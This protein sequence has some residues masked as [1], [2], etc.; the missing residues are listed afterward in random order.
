MG[1]ADLEAQGLAF[2]P[3]PSRRLGKSL[4]VNNIPAKTCSYA[5][6]YCQLG[7]TTN[8]TTKR[9]H[10]YKPADISREVERKI[11]ESTSK[12]ESINYV[13]F[14]ADGEPTLDLN[15]G[16]EIS[17]LKRIGFPIAVLTN[18][19]LI[20]RKGIKE[21]LFKADFISVKV[22]AVSKHLW[23]RINRPH[24][25]LKLDTVLQGIT[26][27]AKEYKGRLVSETMLI[28]KVEYGDEFER[29]A[30]FLRRLKR[31]TKA[32]IAIPTRP[33]AED[34]VEPANETTINT[35]FQIFSEKLGVDRVEY[36]IG[37]EGNAFAF[38]GRVV[39]DL[40]SITAVHP[41]RTEA[42]KALLQKANADWAVVEDLLSEGKLVELKYG[43]STYYM[44]SLPSRI[45]KHA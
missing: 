29:V 26:E 7:N 12:R 45:C 34:W 20:L 36:L 16:K 1:V 9:Q 6:V 10:F 44:R 33:P 8:M 13:T 39:D 22:D 41:M 27:L 37:Y 32:Y 40:L 3:V 38:T 21:E 35:A 23:R 17:L 11:A 43:G 19:S 42:V 18:A 2:G 25:D 4:G 24:K 30:D 15:L 14:V 28:D 31:L 5:C